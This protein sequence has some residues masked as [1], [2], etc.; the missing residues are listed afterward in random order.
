[1]IINANYTE[2][3]Y[4]CIVLI[5][6]SRNEKKYC[7]FHLKSALQI[8]WSKVLSNQDYFVFFRK[9]IIVKNLK[10]ATIKQVIIHL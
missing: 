1:M 7:P 3:I 6:V 2:I 8:Y 5:I 4:K 10:A 9:H